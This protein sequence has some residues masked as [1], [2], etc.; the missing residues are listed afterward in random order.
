MSK[1]TGPICGLAVLMLFVGGHAFSRPATSTPIADN[2][3][4]VRGPITSYDPDTGCATIGDSEVFVG[5]VAADLGIDLAVGDDLTLLGMQFSSAG[6]IWAISID[7][8]PNRNVPIASA[9]AVAAKVSITGTGTTTQSITGT[10][11]RTQSITGTG[12]QS[13]TGTGIATQSITGTGY[14]AKSLTGI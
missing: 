6:L 11:I 12:K 13:I 1:R 14:S 3:V 10:G 2:T 5:D 9:P 4:L 8:P 7:F